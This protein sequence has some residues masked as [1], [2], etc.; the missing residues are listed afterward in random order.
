M[1][2]RL[3]HYIDIFLY[4]LLPRIRLSAPRQTLFKSHVIIQRQFQSM[5]VWCVSPSIIELLF[6]YDVLVM[7]H[8]ALLKFKESVICMPNGD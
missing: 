4:F 8:C 6:V 2:I 7:F 5:H 1:S 3:K